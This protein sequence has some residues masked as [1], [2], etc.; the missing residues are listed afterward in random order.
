MLSPVFASLHLRSRGLHQRGEF[1]SGDA[2]IDAIPEGFEFPI[3][4][5][6]EAFAVE[7]V[8]QIGLLPQ[9]E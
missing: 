8:L 5:G 9:P 6:L 1:L 3:Y 7:F 2:R 4:L